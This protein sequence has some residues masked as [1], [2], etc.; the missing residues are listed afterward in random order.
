MD[1]LEWTECSETLEDLLQN[2]RVQ[3]P[4]II[5]LSSTIT[6]V[7]T[8]KKLEKG[9][10]VVIHAKEKLDQLEGTDRNGKVLRIPFSCPHKIRRKVTPGKEKIFETIKELARTEPLPR[11]VEVKEAES[12]SD[13][14]ISN[15][16]R[17]KVVIVE[18]T[19]GVPSFIHFRSSAGKHIK[20]SIDEK[21]SFQLSV[22]D[23]SEQFISKLAEKSKE[24]PISAEFFKTK[25]LP[26]SHDEIG[27]F[28]IANSVTDNVVIASATLN[29]KEC[30]ILFPLN[31]NF[32]FQVNTKVK[33]AKDESYRQLCT[34]ASEKVDAS[35]IVLFFG[36]HNPFDTDASYVVE[37]KKL[38][39]VLKF[40]YSE[41]YDSDASPQTDQKSSK[42]EKVKSSK[43]SSIEDEKNQ[44]QPSEPEEVEE[45]S[46]PPN[47]LVIHSEQKEILKRELKEKEKQA[48]LEKDR[49][50]AEKK[51]E[52]K[53]KKEREREEKSIKKKKKLSSSSSTPSSPIEIV[54]DD[55]YL[56][57]DTIG[58]EQSVE[59]SAVNEE[60]IDNQSS[61]IA[62]YLMNKVKKVRDRTQ[63]LGAKKQKK[64]GKLRKEDIEF[65]SND[66]LDRPASIYTVLEGGDPFAESLY[67]AL[68]GDLAYESLDLVKQAQRSLAV[69]APIPTENSGDSGFDE[70]DQARIQAW[71]DTMAPP[72]LPG[73][74]PVSQKQSASTG[75]DENLY[76]M[77]VDSSN[78]QADQ[79]SA[80]QNFYDSVQQSTN[81]ISSWDMEDI[82]ECLTDL[83]LGKYID[84]F[85]DSQV[86][87]QL[88]LDLDE[89]VL[90]D[91]GLTP[92]EARKLRKFVFG[93]RPDNIRPETYPSLKGFDCKDPAEWSQKDVLSH[94]KTIEINDFANFCNKNQVNGV[95]LKDICVDESIMSTIITTK[96]RKLKSVKIKNYVIDQWR[97]KKKG[98]G[99]YVSSSSISS[100]RKKSSSPNTGNRNASIATRSPNT[101]NRSPKVQGSPQ[102][103][104]RKKT[105]ENQSCG[106][107]INKKV[108]GDAP[109]IAKMKMQLEENQH[110]WEKKKPVQFI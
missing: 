37:Y 103:S 42:K 101:G 11:F 77:A 96:D 98:E 48:K 90:I 72:P 41:I 57:P 20:L 19:G 74:H 100:Q 44:P 39:K 65:V 102:T 104:Q 21:I 7:N 81:E 3:L 76:E 29:N 46:L 24:F 70:I 32:K 58:E 97:P 4:Q 31:L 83:Q 110:S 36:H 61:Q 67:E 6:D 14:G 82:A 64:R 79:S 59:T 43:K 5:K 25:E 71:R 68:P 27:I 91:L 13:I 107:G 1:Q 88:L 60:I 34:S 93:W 10:V 80:W 106:L 12:N 16:D 63:S 84:T 95:L 38:L 18:K 55:L 75:Y 33:M 109:L 26:N 9:Q 50:K 40:D 66:Q 23:G 78:N 47:T 45:E 54:E 17:L 52:K 62:M 49:I 92:F 99:N 35:E 30:G 89:S 73:N 87:G 53:E 2:P 86:D 94:L 105:N 15:G 69:P 51:K 85:A 28:T 8:K 22:N 56:D 108:V